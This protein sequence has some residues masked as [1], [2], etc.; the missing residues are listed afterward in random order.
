M[1][2]MKVSYMDCRMDCWMVVLMVYWKGRIAVVELALHL[3]E[4]LVDMTVL[5][6]V[7]EMAELL[8]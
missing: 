1:A 2:G 3:V 4:E 5:Y 8:D 7:V 6:S